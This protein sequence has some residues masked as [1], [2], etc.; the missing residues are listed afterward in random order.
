VAYI[1][2]DLQVAFQSYK[3]IDDISG[4]FDGVITSFPLTVNGT[5]PVPLPINSQQCTISVGGVIQ[6][7]DDTGTE[8]F[9]L[10]GSNIEFSSAPNIGED[11]FG[12]I[13]AGADYINV[14]AKFPAGSAAV[15]SVTFENNLNTGLF[16]SGTNQLSV[17]TAGT[18]RFRFT[19][20]GQNQSVSLGTNAEPAFSFTN[21]PNTGI[22][23]PGADQVAISTNGSERL[24]I[25][26]TGQLGLGTSSPTG[27]LTVATDA[28]AITE[29]SYFV[30]ENRTDGV[31]QGIQQT[32]KLRGGALT[33]DRAAGF[34]R[35]GVDTA[36]GGD[37]TGGSTRRSYMAFAT[38]NGS[39]D[40]ER[41]RIDSSGRLLVGTSTAS[42]SAL[43]QV[44]GDLAFDSG[45]GSVATAYGCRAW[46][47]FNG[48]GTVAIR[49]SGNVSSITDRGTGRYTINFT[50]A[51]PDT[52]YS[53]GGTTGNSDADRFRS[54]SVLGQ[55][56]TLVGSVQIQ[57]GYSNTSAVDGN[58]VSVQ[59]F[60]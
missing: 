42:G 20:N 28:S 16:N 60:R 48:E 14:G 1:G 32:F 23:S 56:T 55:A 10:V 4:L 54:L 59:I 51:M 2:N 33:T 7:P 38:A 12:V 8:G 35:I 21:D 26:S 22:Y 30:N 46:V 29:N 50:T 39:T 19:S 31:S 58:P 40:V 25:D 13:L 24:R 5:T 47:N 41:A 15:P 37:Y 18:E 57:T 3:N 52:N 34:I 27:K 44:D 36:N 45:Y 17:T 43:L 6:K 11:F 49:G 53:I 9:R